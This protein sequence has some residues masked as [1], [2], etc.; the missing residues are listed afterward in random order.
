LTYAATGRKL[1]ANNKQS[2]EEVIVRL[3]DKSPSRNLKLTMLVA[4][5][6]CFA[7]TSASA[8]KVLRFATTLPPN[9]PLVSQFFEPWAK[10]VN[11]AA[12]S[13]F[14]IQVVNGPTFANAVNVWERTSDGIVDIGWGIHGAVSLPFPKS[15]IVSLPLLVKEGQLGAAAAAL[16]TLYET[17]LIA[18][19][20][21]NVKPLALV[22]TPVQG[23]SAR[24]PV[25][26]LE[27]MRGLKVRAADRTVSDVVTVLGGS[28]ISIPATGVYQALGQGVVSA[29][30]AGWVLIGSFRLD[31]VVK[32]HVEGVPLG[33]PSGFVIMNKNSY[34]SLSPKGQ[35]I[36]DQYAG[37]RFSREFGEFFEGLAGTF[38]NKAKADSSH[39]FWKIDEAEGKRWESALQPV[40]DKWV[41]TTPD[42]NKIFPSFRE[43]I[44]RSGK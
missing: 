9:N 42:G 20:Y 6:V 7:A 5:A 38:R 34:A 16:W 32:E 14:Q 26:K 21:K 22:A 44:K 31:E 43:S 39:R 18:D 33:A 1:S 19:E 25:A 17:G 2:R 11:A 15:N 28:P 41:E 35:E 37:E 12:G 23:L 29:S 27:D 36:L 13:E 40:I 3:Q 24:V 10:R 8:Q 30:V 4:L